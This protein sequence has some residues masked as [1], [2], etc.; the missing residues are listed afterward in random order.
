MKESIAPKGEQ[1]GG[2][3]EENKKEEKKVG[4]N[5]NEYLKV[6]GIE[7]PPISVRIFFSGHGFAKDLE[8]FS[9]AMKDVD[10]VIP[11]QV[12]SGVTESIQQ[13]LDIPDDKLIRT[14]PYLGNNGAASMPIAMC[15]A[16]ESGKARQGDRVMFIGGSGGFSAGVVAMIL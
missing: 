11:H 13:A 2:L 4:K 7:A 8:G 3:G 14:F 1:S 15:E 10:I 12:A 16:L 6:Q 5:I 9:E